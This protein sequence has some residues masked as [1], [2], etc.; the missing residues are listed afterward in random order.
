MYLILRKRKKLQHQKLAE[1]AESQMVYR[2]FHTWLNKY[3]S[4]KRSHEIEERIVLIET[5]FLKKRVFNF[6]RTGKNL[7]IRK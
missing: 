1:Y 5:V 4:R 6:L 7:E 2:V 3:E